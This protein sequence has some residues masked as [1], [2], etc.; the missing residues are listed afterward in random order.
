[1]VLDV[2]VGVDVVRKAVTAAATM[3]MEE[4]EEEEEEEEEEAALRTTKTW[5][6]YCECLIYIILS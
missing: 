1:M 2:V 3:K 4:K 6:D 5:F